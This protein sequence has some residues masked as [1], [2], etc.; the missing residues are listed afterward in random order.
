MLHEQGL[1]EHGQAL[2]LHRPVAEGAGLGEPP[3]VERRVGGGV[4]HD[5]VQAPLLVLDQLG[6]G[7]LLAADLAPGQPQATAVSA[8]R[9]R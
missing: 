4:A 7:P 3:A 5:G 6:A 9:R 8:R 1:V 2:E